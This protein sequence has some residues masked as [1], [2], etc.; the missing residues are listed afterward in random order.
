MDF[1][2][3]QSIPLSAIPLGS[4]IGRDVTSQYTRPMADPAPYMGNEFGRTL[5]DIL[6]MGQAMYPQQQ[7]PQEQYKQAQYTPNFYSQG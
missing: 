1:G 7:Y 6:S 2:F 5:G 3:G 4:G